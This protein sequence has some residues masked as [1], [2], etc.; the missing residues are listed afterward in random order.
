MQF[1]YIKLYYTYWG[2]YSL[3]QNCIWVN[4]Y[5]N[6]FKI[7]IKYHIMPL[8]LSA[9]VIYEYKNYVIKNMRLYKCPFLEDKI[10]M[11]EVVSVYI[12]G[13]IT[14]I[15]KPFECKI[16]KKGDYFYGKIRGANP[17]EEMGLPPCETL[18][19]LYRFKET[20][21]GEETQIAEGMFLKEGYLGNLEDEAKK[22]LKEEEI[23]IMLKSIIFHSQISGLADL[24]NNAFNSFE[25]ERFQDT[26]TACRKI[27]EGIDEII[28]GWKSIDNSKSVYEKLRHVIKSLFSFASIGGPHRGIVTKEETELI[29]KT[30]YDC[31]I[32][33][34]SILKNDR[35]QLPSED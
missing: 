31:L 35:F 32:Y 1:F 21:E 23:R 12:D 4:F 16:Y 9:E 14:K 26:K 34:N 2:E 5:R 18:F 7:K 8:I 6:V 24:L 11:G 28:S 17:F 25:E 27:L 29:L 30:T 15:N 3:L 33:I 22:L 10:V 20:T 19:I 13:K